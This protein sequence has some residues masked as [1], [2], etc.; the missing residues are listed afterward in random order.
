[1]YNAIV[2]YISNERKFTL[3]NE[4][5]TNNVLQLTMMYFDDQEVHY[6]QVYY[7]TFTIAIPQVDKWI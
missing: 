1:M 5:F 2:I 4:I 6:H 3:Q 7:L